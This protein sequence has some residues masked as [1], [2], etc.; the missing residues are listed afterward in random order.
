MSS[1]T[2]QTFDLEAP[3]GHPRNAKV[4][5]VADLKPEPI[6]HLLLVLEV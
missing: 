3:Q 1:T 4:P 2:L 6:S 5:Y